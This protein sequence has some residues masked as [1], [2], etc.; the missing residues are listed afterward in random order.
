ML[1]AVWGEVDEPS[2]EVVQR[3]I[4]QPFHEFKHPQFGTVMRLL[5]HEEHFSIEKAKNSAPEL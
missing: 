4:K 1:P 5:N 2:M 3:L